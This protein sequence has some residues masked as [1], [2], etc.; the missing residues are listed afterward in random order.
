MR[1]IS[2]AMMT[3]MKD[4]ISCFSTLVLYKDT[5]G[6]PQFYG[7]GTLVRVADRDCLLTAAHVWE[8]AGRFERV[9]LATGGATRG[10]ALAI[11]RDL[12]VPLHVSPRPTGGWNQWGPDVALIAIPAP[13]ASSLRAA[14]KAFYNLSMRRADALA[15]PVKP[16]EGIWFIV[17]GLGETAVSRGRQ[18]DGAD[19]L[20]LDLAALGSRVRATTTRGGLDYIDVSLSNKLDPDFPASYGG[21][22]GSG[23]WCVGETRGTEVHWQDGGP[24]TLEGVVFLYRDVVGAPEDEIIR[25]HGRRSVYDHL[26]TVAGFPASLAAATGSPNVTP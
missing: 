13:Y 3:A 14:G 11:E 24:V 26:L 4:K 16:G 20:Y 2:N 15:T 25:C 21:L 18:A 1:E 12:F 8:Q 17:G 10:Q 19:G 7:S 23:L 22:S 6:L 9:A 5:R